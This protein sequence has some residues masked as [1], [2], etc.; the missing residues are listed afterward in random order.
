[1]FQTKSANKKQAYR[2]LRLFQNILNHTKFSTKPY[3]ALKQYG[4]IVNNK[5][6]VK[7][8]QKREIN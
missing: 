4:M 7:Q 2:Y 3:S 8:V 6:L 1:M 5:P